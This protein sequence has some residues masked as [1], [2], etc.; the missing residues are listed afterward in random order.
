MKKSDLFKLT[1][2][3]RVLV[4]G[5]QDYET[6]SNEPGVVNH[7]SDKVGTYCG[8]YISVLFDKW[9]RG[10]GPRNWNFYGDDARAF[11]ITKEKPVAAVVKKA[12]KGAQAYKGNGKHEWELVSRAT[13]RLRVPG[14]WLY[15][16]STDAGTMVFVPVPDVVG[17]PI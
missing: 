8:G 7:V 1:V 2:D 10:E 3:Q 14:G 17:Y 5:T 6:F 16:D 13:F 9:S 15:R 12:P 4:T 11:S